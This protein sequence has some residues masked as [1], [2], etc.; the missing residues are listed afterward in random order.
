MNDV[1]VTT[2]ASASFIT[3]LLQCVMV[4]GCTTIPLW[5]L[6][7]CPG[8][9]VTSMCF[10]NH[11]P[12]PAAGGGPPSAPNLVL[13]RSNGCFEVRRGSGVVRS[14]GFDRRL[15]GV[16][17]Q[18][19]W[20]P[21]AHLPQGAGADAAWPAS[22]QDVSRNFNFNIVDCASLAC[23]LVM[24][25]VRWSPSH[26]E[27]IFATFSG[28]ISCFSTAPRTESDFSEA[29][30]LS[31]VTQP[32]KASNTSAA[33]A[34]AL[35]A[36]Q[37]QPG[38]TLPGTHATAPPPPATSDPDASPSI[39]PPPKS[40]PRKP[41]PPPSAPSATPSSFFSAIG[42]K[43][44]L[45]GGSGR[46]DAPATAADALRQQKEERAQTISSLHVWPPHACSAAAVVTRACRRRL[47]S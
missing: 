47:P 31:A 7:P 39:V 30:G 25:R 17:L 27:Y 13:G 3:L 43:L 41:S 8:A 5:T 28:S 42:E 16:R 38:V 14:I 44:G 2:S 10:H 37:P 26:D 21:P 4:E 18:R 36:P 9:A 29:M 40:L 35:L 22:R 15:A 24:T 20:H 12:A 6:P 1:W 34:A 45:V 46:S 32:T 11:V 33:A 19:G 23:A